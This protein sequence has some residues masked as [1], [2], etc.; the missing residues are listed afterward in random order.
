MKTS[1]VRKKQPRLYDKSKNGKIKVWDI[2]VETLHSE[3]LIKW[4]SG[5]EDG[6]L[7]YHSKPITQGKNIGKKNETSPYEQAVKEMQAKWQKKRD[8]GMV[9]HKSNI[10]SIVSYFPMLAET[11]YSQWSA[12]VVNSK[13]EITTL[14]PR[15]L[16]QKKLNG[17]RCPS[18]KLAD[19]VKLYSRGGKDYTQICDVLT[20]HLTSLMRNGEIWDGEI[21][22]HG[23]SF[24]RIVQAVKRD[25]SKVWRKKLLYWVKKRDWDKARWW[26]KTRNDT[27]KLEYHRYDAPSNDSMYDR[28]H[29]MCL[30]PTSDLVHQ[31]EGVILGGENWH[32]IKYWHDKFVAEGYEGVVLRDTEAAY[33][34]NHR[35]KRLYKYKEFE[36]AEFE[37]IGYHDGEG[38]DEGAVTWEC[39]DTGQYSHVY[40]DCKPRGSIADRR[41]LYKRGKAY[42]GKMLTVRFQSRS[43]KDVPLFPVGIAIRDYE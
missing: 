37:I 26:V 15:V 27:Q 1:N 17:V 33:L 7:S 20:A 28:W 30:L 11:A 36:D 8:K 10:G 43:D 13:K 5:Y 34:W 40:F 12:D 23:W 2:W 42:I 25:K 31:V 18:V 14:A 4:R 6:K 21:Y 32:G 35:D 29:R 38:S 39:R 41:R 19:V 3:A 24:E 16:L 22:K 9:T